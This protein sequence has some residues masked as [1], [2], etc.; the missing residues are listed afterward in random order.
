M[1]KRKL[2]NKEIRRKLL[3]AVVCAVFLA[4]VSLLVFPVRT[5]PANETLATKATGI[6]NVLGWMDVVPDS[7]HWVEPIQ[8]YE[9]Q[10]YLDGTKSKDST[11]VAWVSA[12]TSG[13]KD[14]IRYANKVFV[15]WWVPNLPNSSPGYFVT[16]YLEVDR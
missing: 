16:S 13:N 9:V 3:V 7:I 10:F 5:T 1:E 15:T 11:R 6:A 8:M 4:T 2:S 12:G 14:R